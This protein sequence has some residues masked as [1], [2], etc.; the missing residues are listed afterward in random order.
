MFVSIDKTHP[1][2]QT[3][4]YL[5]DIVPFN[6]MEIIKEYPLFIVSNERDVILGTTSPQNPI[7][8]WTSDT[9]L[10]FSIQELCDY[11]YERFSSYQ[12]ICYVAKPN[13]AEKI[14]LQFELNRAVKASI[15]NMESFECK[16]VIPAKNSSVIIEHPILDD[17][18]QIA[19]CL[20]A[21]DL[22]C[23]GDN[24]PVDCYLDKAKEL[25]K[26]NLCFVIKKD[27][28]IVAMAKSSRE[29]ATH[30]AVN[31]VYTKPGHRGKGY[32]AA[33][34]AH[35]SQIILNKGKTP[36]LYTDLANPSSNKAYKNV[37]FTECGK[38]DEV[39]LTW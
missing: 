14:K 29:T 10:N 31:G 28:Q 13:I 22:D 2:F 37:G 6:L 34:V 18:H 8:V 35:I 12:T 15:V 16:T 4:A 23:F 1:I 25:V 32:A 33:I 7:W 38:V 3:S 20:S 19:E 39:S 24:E 11:M 17:V 27:K 5:K 9:V 21:F 30:I 36:V 26:S